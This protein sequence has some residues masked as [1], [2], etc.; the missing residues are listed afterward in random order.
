MP[1]GTPP[2]EI[3]PMKHDRWPK[4]LAYDGVGTVR[5]IVYG[6]RCRS[7]ALLSAKVLADGYYV[8]TV[9][10][11][12]T[13]DLILW[14]GVDRLGNLDSIVWAEYLAPEANAPQSAKPFLVKKGA[15]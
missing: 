3:G 13:K 2:Y 8:P 4:W 10:P 11:V 9:E 6:T 1:V 5:G 12:T 15:A 7:L 14:I